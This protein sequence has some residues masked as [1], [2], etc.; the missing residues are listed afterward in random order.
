MPSTAINI[1]RLLLLIGIAGYIYGMTTAYASLTALIPAG[2]GIVLLLLGHLAQAKESLRKHLMHAA[3]LVA[4]IG[5]IASMGGL[6]SRFDKAALPAL[7]SQIAMA[8][9]CLAFVVLSVRSFINAR[10]NEQ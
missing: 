5:F 9:V 2:F 4:L 8:L 10:K 1:G 7:I 6:I 3:V